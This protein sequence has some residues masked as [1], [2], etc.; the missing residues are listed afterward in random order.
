M[1]ENNERRI[2]RSENLHQALS[3]Q[4]KHVRERYG[5]DRVALVE[6]SGVF[7]PGSDEPNLDQ[8]A[9]SFAQAIV[10]S[11]P[12]HGQRLTAELRELIPCAAVARVE[13]R[14][15]ELHGHSAFICA[16]ADESAD[17]RAAFD[18]SIGGL[19]RIAATMPR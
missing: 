11:E 6:D 4:L 7:V 19:Q 18:H 12:E 8:A 16:V 9:A 10:H 13:L 17:L 5:L 14:E 3:Y 2:R 1:H 15:F